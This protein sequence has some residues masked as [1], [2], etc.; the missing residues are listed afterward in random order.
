M[1]MVAPFAKVF[2][3]G[4]I[5]TSVIAIILGIGFGFFLE[6]AGFGSAKTL[7]GVWYGYDFAVIRVMFTAILVSMLGLFGLHYAG[8]LNL[9]LVYINGTYVWPQIVGGFIFGIGFNVGQYCP[10]TSAVACATG[11]IDGFVFI[12]GFLVGVVG[13]AFVFPWIEPFF[14]SSNMGRITL[15]E[16]F[17]IPA[18]VVVLGVVLIALGA[19]A[20][21]HFLDRKLGNVPAG[22]EK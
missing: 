1:E 6:K 18:G 10:G 21:T 9:D 2:S 4:D 17:G 3:M 5:P 12:F 7:A 19:F 14:N 11:R 22:G 8:V 13:F 15:P 20:F 16:A